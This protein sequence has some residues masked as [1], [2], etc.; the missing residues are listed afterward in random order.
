M[1]LDPDSDLGARLVTVAVGALPPEVVADALDRGA[2]EAEAFLG[3][4]L[5]AAALLSLSGDSRSIGKLP[6]AL[7]GAAA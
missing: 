4:G 5:I 2:A 7:L 6:P 1:E 3:R